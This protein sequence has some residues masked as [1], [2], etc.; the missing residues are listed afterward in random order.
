MKTP[1]TIGAPD[2]I[3]ISFGKDAPPE[4]IAPPLTYNP[5]DTEIPP[6]MFNFAKS[7]K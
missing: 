3:L 7:M 1:P 4:I 2:D 5:D 6:A